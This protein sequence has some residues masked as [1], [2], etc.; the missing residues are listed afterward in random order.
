MTFRGVVGDALRA[1]LPAA[2]LSG[3]PS[4]LFAVATGRDPLEPSVAAGSIIRPEEDR[5]GRLLLAA[6]PVHLSLSAFWA[7]LMAVLLPRKK[8]IREGIVAGLAIAGIDL[9]LIGRR[10]P[11]IRSL[12]PLPQ[13]AD[14]V[15]FG[16]IAS[17]ALSSRERYLENVPTRDELERVLKLLGADD[18]RAMMRIDEPEYKDLNLESAT[19]DQLLDAMVSHPRLI[20][21]PIVIRGNRA[22]I[23]RPPDRVIELLNDEGDPHV[24]DAARK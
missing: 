21:R 6:I 11:L 10:Y 22:V 18:P 5:R 8:P 17:L 16:V 2:I 4:T 7:I 20:Q 19:R 14:H 23:G 1:A 9:G 3:A 15:A 12:D 24:G 13:V